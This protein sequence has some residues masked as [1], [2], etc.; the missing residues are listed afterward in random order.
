[1]E[2]PELA[3]LEGASFDALVIGSG[4][5]GLAAAALLTQEAG[6]RVL[7]LERHDVPGGFTH[8]FSRNGWEWDVGL[9]YVGGVMGRQTPIRKLFD[10]ISQGRLTWESLGEVY[11]TVIVGDRTFELAAGR[12]QWLERMTEAFP[13][14]RNV[15]DNYLE[16]V[17]KTVS[18][19]L[20]FFESKALPPAV[21]VIA[22]WAMRRRFHSFSDRTVGQVLDDLTDDPLLRTVLTAQYGDYGLPP[23]RASW[24]IHAMV[25]EH[26]MDGAGYPV[27]GSASLAASITPV[28]TGAGG[29]VVTRAEVREVLVEGGRAVGVRLTDGLELKAPVVISDAGAAVTAH[30]L[31]PEEAPGRRELLET[32]ERIGPSSGHACLHVGLDATAEEL[33]LGRSNLWVYPGPGH[34]ASMEIYRHDPSAPLPLAFISFPSAKDPTFTTRHPGKATIEV[35]GWVPFAWFERWRHTSWKRRGDEYEAFKDQLAAR[36]MDVLEQHV[37][38][39][40]G[41][42]A[43]SELS[44]PL[45]TRWFCNY[46]HG[47]IYGLDHTPRRFREHSLRP[48]TPLRGFYL[49]GADVC[50]AGIAGALFGGVLA[51]S[52]ILGRNLLKKV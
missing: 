19:S 22:G 37:P 28:I 48:R 1:M 52:S 16:L 41:H 6:W 11:D 39:V 30:T 40:T 26:Y 33:G 38:Q 44:T 31:L 8:T 42:V 9:H 35:V 29:R 36:Y 4:I 47:E 20:T 25:V 18:A 49:T 10:R 3:E 34:D 2:N 17:S 43:F 13:G 32:V 51:A 12:R 50:T 21:D 5:G 15:L 46:E 14:S 45:T 7:V 24:A 27:G 23:S